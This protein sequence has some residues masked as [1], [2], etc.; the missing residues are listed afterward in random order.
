MMFYCSIV[1]GVSEGYSPLKRA[2]AITN[3]I[4]DQ[5][6]ILMRYYFSFRIEEIILFLFSF[7]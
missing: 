2:A 3:F 4:S 1:E 6:I 7:I 5:K